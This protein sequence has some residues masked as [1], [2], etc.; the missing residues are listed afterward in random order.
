M[1]EAIKEASV[2][3]CRAI[4]DTCAQNHQ[5]TQVFTDSA[6][7]GDFFSILRPEYQQ[8]IRQESNNSFSFNMVLAPRSLIMFFIYFFFFAFRW[9]NTCSNKITCSILYQVYSAKCYLTLQTV[10]LKHVC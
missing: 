8:V 4:F 6:N 3:C 9:L 10:P 2:V 5:N 1:G 7:S